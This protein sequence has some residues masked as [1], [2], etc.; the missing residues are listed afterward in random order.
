M[1]IGLV[2]HFV[3]KNHKGVFQN[4]FETKILQLGRWNRKEYSEERVRQTYIHNAQR[5]LDILPQ[6]V[7]LGIRHFRFTSD[8]LPLSDKVPREWWDNSKLR[9]IFKAIGDYCRK[10]NIRP[11]FHPGQFCVLSSNRGDVVKNA[12]DELSRHAWI[13]DACEFPQTTFASINIHAGRKDAFL[14]LAS[15][16]DLLPHNVRSRLTFENDESTASVKELYDVYEKTKIPILFDSHHHTF[17]TGDLSVKGAFDLAC[18]T[19]PTHI[20]PVQHISNTE[21]DLKNGSFT[22]RRK[23]SQFIESIPE[24]QLEGLMKQEIALEVEAKMKN[25]AIEKMISDFGLASIL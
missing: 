24:P 18:S 8:F 16:V 19:W 22:D 3:K 23:H 5:H 15:N 9:G 17:R 7:S 25:V 2:C 14:E 12:V 20:M 11:S 6:V 13:F 21:N 10:E 1:P 4:I